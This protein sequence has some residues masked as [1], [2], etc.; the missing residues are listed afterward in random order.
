MESPQER[1]EPSSAISV[2]A[3]GHGLP[4]G[5]D[6]SDWEERNSYRTSGGSTMTTTTTAD[7][8]LPRAKFASLIARLAGVR[9]AAT[10][11]LTLML[12]TGVGD[13]AGDAAARGAR[14]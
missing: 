2:E 9:R 3:R 13:E 1:S 4:R 5:H 7:R 12:A 10:L 6:H 11:A 14:S 8:D